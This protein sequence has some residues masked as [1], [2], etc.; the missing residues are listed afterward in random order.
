[1]L[2]VFGDGGCSTVDVVAADFIFKEGQEMTVWATDYANKLPVYIEAPII[3]GS[4][5]V[6]LESFSNLRNPMDAKVK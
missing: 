2:E 5:R 3:V 1:M 6:E 4:V